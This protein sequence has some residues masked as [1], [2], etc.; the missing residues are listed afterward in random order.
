MVGKGGE[1]DN[2]SL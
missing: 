2:K 1:Q